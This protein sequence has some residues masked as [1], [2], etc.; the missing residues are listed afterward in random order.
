[1]V[2]TV[3]LPIFRNLRMNCRR[4]EA[5]RGKCQ[6]AS[7]GKALTSFET[8]VSLAFTGLPRWKYKRR[9]LRESRYFNMFRQYRLTEVHR[10]YIGE[11]LGCVQLYFH[12]YRGIS[13]NIAS[14]ICCFLHIITTPFYS[15]N[16]Q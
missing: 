4:A 16:R 13:V 12:G 9:R 10:G 3:W 14:Y 5:L 11:E 8:S 7:A 2:G 15:Y 6:A 1:M